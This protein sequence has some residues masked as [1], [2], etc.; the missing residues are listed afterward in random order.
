MFLLASWVSCWGEARPSGSTNQRSTYSRPLSQPPST[1]WQIADESLTI[2]EESLIAQGEP[3]ESLSASLPE[4]YRK[5]QELQESVNALSQR[6]GSFEEYL[7]SLDR[8]MTQAIK[9]FRALAVECRI[10][11]TV[12]VAGV[13]GT[14]IG[15]FVS[16]FE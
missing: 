3:V 2:I 8:N 4:L 14:V 12:A 15:I 1:L 10:W 9:A 16:F 6:F 5:S 11:K 13:T 7:T